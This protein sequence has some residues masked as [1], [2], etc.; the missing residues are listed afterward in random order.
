[1]PRIEPGSRAPAFSIP[2]QDGRTRALKDYAGRPV[3]LYFYPG[4]DTPTCAQEACDF[5]DHLPD[6][7]KVKAVVI[8]ISPNDPDSHRRFV[9]KHDLNMTLLA[10]VP[11]DDGVPS[12][13]D[14]YGTWGGKSMFGRRFQGVIRTTYLIGPDGRVVRRWDNV[15]VKGHVRR[16]LDAVHALEGSAVRKH[17]KARKGRRDT[18]PAYGPVR[19]PGSDRRSTGQRVSG[20]RR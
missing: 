7:R 6:F 5:R 8:G 16:V 20:R 11:G 10:D 17:P 3:V 12:T 14:A 13:C 4:D 19:G 9:A 2:D 15:R 18:D 1:M